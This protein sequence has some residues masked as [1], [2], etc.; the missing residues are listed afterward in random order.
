MNKNFA[1]ENQIEVLTGKPRQQL[2]KEDL[3]NLINE[4]QIE[5]LT[6]HYTAIDGKV[7]ELRLPVTSKNQA[8]IVL[9]E[10]E[11][12]DG[13]SLFKGVVNA[14]ES[15]LYVIP[16]YKTA[17]I[18]PFD[19]TSLDFICRFVTGNGELAPFAPDN[20]LHIT[21]EKLKEET[22]IEFHALGELEFY[23]VGNVGE[24]L[25][26][27]PNQKG[28]HGSSPYVKTTDIV[29]EMLRIM[30]NITSEIKYA[31]NEVGLINGLDCDNAL[32]K[33]KL[34]EQ[35]EI[36]FLPE[37]VEDAA[38]I[39]VLG[40]WLCQ[41]VANR[42]GLIATFSPKIQIGDAGSGLHF[43]AMLKRNNKNIMLNAD[44]ELSEDAMKLIG[45]L[46][47]YASTLS[48]FGNMAAASFLR[49]VPHQEAPT[50][51]CW[52]YSNRSALIRVPLGWRNLDNLAMMVNPQ[53]KLRYDIMDSRQTVEL[54][55]PDGSANTHLLLAGMTTA[56]LWAYRNPREA[57]ALAEKN[58]VK[59]N[60]HDEAGLEEQLTDIATSCVETAETLSENR[61]LYTRDGYFPEALIDKVIEM[62]TAQNDRGLNRRITELPP[63]EGEKLAKDFILKSLNDC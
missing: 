31:H 52:G 32:Y 50:K 22:G 53:Q 58:F 41:S 63:E 55:S 9:A 4:R 5:R 6:F 39:V 2:T 20:I 44:Q 24:N 3:I 12:V 8:E 23:L 30:T 56:L 62:L 54:R 21:H 42:H 36:E 11:R 28:Y 60:I 29:N 38:D 48:S 26:P 61:D 34:A 47:R 25:Y 49:L 17:F 40:K 14:G 15:D 18:N 7:K 51:V 33:D 57:L 43:H 16:V 37:P 59:G 35:V 19:T 1:L 10:G 27:L 46:C 13:S 45:G